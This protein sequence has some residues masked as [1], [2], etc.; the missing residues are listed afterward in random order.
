MAE[1]VVTHRFETAA[2]L[3]RRLITASVVVPQDQMIEVQVS[4][5]QARRVGREIE[6]L[7][8][9]RDGIGAAEQRLDEMRAEMQ[10]LHD[11]AQVVLNKA[12]MLLMGSGVFCL[13]GGLFWVLA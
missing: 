12:L 4:T 8:A 7:V 9:L 1:S 5:A 11:S 2:D 10:Q 13:A 6:R 3:G